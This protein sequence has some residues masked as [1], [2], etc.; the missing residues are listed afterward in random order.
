MEP[1]KTYHF[2]ANQEQQAQVAALMEKD[3]ER[4]FQRWMERVL[5]RLFDRMPKAQ[6][7]NANG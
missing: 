7:E 1:R 5:E 6:R 3:G 4:M 2:K